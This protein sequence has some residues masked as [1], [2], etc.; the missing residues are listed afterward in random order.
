MSYADTVDYQ[1]RKFG[2]AATVSIFVAAAAG[3]FLNISFLPDP[4]KMPDRDRSLVV[5][6]VPGI[7]EKQSTLKVFDVPEPVKPEPKPKPKPVPVPEPPAEPQKA[8]SEQVDQSKPDPD[9]AEAREALGLPTFW[10]PPPPKVAKEKQ[11]VKEVKKV[12]LPKL[13]VND[14][15]SEKKMDV[16]RPPRLVQ[17]RE[18]RMDDSEVITAVRR[19]QQQL[20]ATPRSQS[21]GSAQTGDDQQSIQDGTVALRF[22]VMSDGR[23]SGCTV[24]ISSGSDVLDRRAC[25]L[26]GT[27]VY[28]AGTDE[29]GSKV[30]KTRIETIEWLGAGDARRG[31]D[32][33]TVT[34]GV[35]P[36]RVVPSAPAVV[37]P[38]ARRR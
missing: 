15:M 4:P 11:E 14:A 10:T 31:S 23:I 38:G 12:E 32:G 25:D 36:S 9:Q 16:N 7:K 30:E 5:F 8:S 34:P 19:L 3:M 2:A 1:A 26:V 27:F 6:P 29:K 22:Q 13:V 20:S 37:P 21:G 35:T 17:A 33:R 24:V 28:E 18:Q